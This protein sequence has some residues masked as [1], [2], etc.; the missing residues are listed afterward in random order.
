MD[1]ISGNQFGPLGD[2]EN[3]NKLKPK[4]RLWSPLHQIINNFFLSPSEEKMKVPKGIKRF[5]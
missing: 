1:L 5:G 2:N 3:P 4:A